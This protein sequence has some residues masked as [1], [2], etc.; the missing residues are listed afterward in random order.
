MQACG[1]SEA[2]EARYEQLS[3]RYQSLQELVFERPVRSW[4]DVIEIAEIAHFWSD[5]TLENELMD[6]ESDDVV[7]RSTAVLILAVLKMAKGGDNG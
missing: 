2:E 5:K 3:D 6:L 7:E 1:D 4:A